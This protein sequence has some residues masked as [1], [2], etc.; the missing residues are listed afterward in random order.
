M[1]NWIKILFSKKDTIK[2]KEYDVVG[3]SSSAKT[4]QIYMHIEEGTGRPYFTSES[5]H[6]QKWC[7]EQLHK[8]RNCCRC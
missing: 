5:I 2:T 4:E 1:I 6:V 7:E 3:I 8:S